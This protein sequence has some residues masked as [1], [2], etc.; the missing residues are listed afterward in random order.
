[1]IIQAIKALGKTKVNIGTIEK[2]SKKLRDNE[3]S[4]MLIE[5]KYSTAWVYEII[6]KICNG[7]L[8]NE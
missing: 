4:K 2:I 7:G 1:L 8:R 3:K 5:A 6:K